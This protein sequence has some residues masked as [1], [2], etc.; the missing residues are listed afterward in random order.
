M[1]MESCHIL[2]MIDLDIYIAHA[3]SDVP[4]NWENVETN[5]ILKKLIDQ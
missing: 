5:L 1:L 2:I 4:Y 3:Q